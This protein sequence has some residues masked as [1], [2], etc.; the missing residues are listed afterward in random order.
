MSDTP[1]DLLSTIAT[2]IVACSF[3]VNREEDLP[4]V[5]AYLRGGEGEDGVLERIVFAT[6]P[7]VSCTG[8]V[9]YQART[10]AASQR[11]LPRVQ[12][13]KMGDKVLYQDNGMLELAPVVAVHNETTPPHYTISLNGSERQTEAAR[14]QSYNNP[15]LEGGAFSPR[16]QSPQPIFSLSRIQDRKAAASQSSMSRVQDKRGN[17]VPSQDVAVHL[18]TTRANLPRLHSYN[19]L[20]SEGG[21]ASLTRAHALLANDSQSR[22]VDY[23]GQFEEDKFSDWIQPLKTLWGAS[24]TQVFQ[25]DIHKMQYLMV[26]GITNQ[27]ITFFINFY[28]DYI[29][30]FGLKRVPDDWAEMHYGFESV[31]VMLYGLH[32]PRDDKLTLVSARVYE[33]KPYE[34]EA[35]LNK[36]W[37]TAKEIHNLVEPT[38]LEETVEQW[39]TTMSSLWVQSNLFAN[40][41]EYENIIRL[42]L[43]GNAEVVIEGLELWYDNYVA[44]FGTVQWAYLKPAYPTPIFRFNATVPWCE[45][46]DDERTCN[47]FQDTTSEGCHWVGKKCDWQPGL[48]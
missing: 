31:L 38:P 46:L 33:L 44:V 6:T 2:E 18:E 11:G 35:A 8:P 26:D 25:D 32:E 22:K 20:S 13:Y 17:D 42:F 5:Q 29:A 43:E 39:Y 1:S 45:S 41:K 48:D 24:K 21:G 47:S 34:N 27:K 12:D 37:T 23:G 10:A 3:L 14:L 16:A 40:H 15:S 4:K 19:D 9:S 28:N 36:I 30:K 7:V